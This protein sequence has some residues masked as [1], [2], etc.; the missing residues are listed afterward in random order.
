MYD[1]C[2]L[3]NCACYNSDFESI[4]LNNNSSHIMNE[5]HSPCH[6]MSE[7]RESQDFDASLDSNSIHSIL[8]KFCFN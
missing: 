6:L 5:M 7:E 2:N 1:Q 8:F 4:N 3:I